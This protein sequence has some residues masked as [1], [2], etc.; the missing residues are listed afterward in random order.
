MAPQTPCL[1][2][3]EQH[4]VAAPQAFPSPVQMLVPVLDWLP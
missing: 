4:S 1:Q 2:M 3:F